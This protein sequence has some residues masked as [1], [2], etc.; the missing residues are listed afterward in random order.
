ME[1]PGSLIFLVVVALFVLIYLT[2][3][4]KK[5]H[6]DVG[7]DVVSLKSKLVEATA[8]VSVLE[9]KYEENMKHL[10]EEQKN[11]LK[12][13][14]L[15]EIE[16]EKKESEK[17]SE[18]SK[19]VQ[20][21]ENE[22]YNLDQQLVLIKENNRKEYASAEQKYSQIYSTEELKKEME[23]VIGE[24]EKAKSLVGNPKMEDVEYILSQ[25]NDVL[26]AALIA[27]YKIVNPA[28]IPR[29]DKT[30]AAFVKS[31]AVNDPIY[32]QQIWGYIVGYFKS[33]FQAFTPEM[34]LKFKEYCKTNIGLFTTA[35]LQSKTLSIIADT[36]SKHILRL[37]PDLYFYKGGGALNPAYVSYTNMSSNGKTLVLAA[38]R[39]F[40]DI[41]KKVM[42][43]ACDAATLEDAIK[44]FDIDVTNMLKHYNQAK[45]TMLISASSFLNS[46]FTNY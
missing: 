22:K 33:A 32:T 37:S 29:L 9:K 6:V 12:R 21:L 2:Y 23:K 39:D 30:F 5:D 11:I 28:I 36:E 24:I 46:T 7:R 44:G 20:S 8:L 34:F 17:Q 19:M 40:E 35:Q 41:V 10:D 45:N 14:K 31:F 42:L 25:S 15:Y 27:Y 16:N 26:I 18:Y 13:L 3:G 1:I 43:K 4:K 38:L